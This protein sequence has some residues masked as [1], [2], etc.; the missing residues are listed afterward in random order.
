M[1]TTDNIWEYDKQHPEGANT[2]KDDTDFKPREADLSVNRQ[3]S[4]SNTS[5]KNER[6]SPM[7][8]LTP[9]DIGESPEKVL[10][11]RRSSVSSQ[12]S[13]ASSRRATGSFG[14]TD[15]IKPLTSF[16]AEQKHSILHATS[17]PLS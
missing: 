14:Q 2:L 10:Q 7:V 12:S 11:R 4:L 16:T 5:H 6:G 17:N 9:E 1:S 15:A 13:R 8:S 3:R